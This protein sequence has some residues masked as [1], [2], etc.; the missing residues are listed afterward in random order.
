MKQYDLFGNEI[1]GGD[2]MK[3]YTTKNMSP[4]YEPK[5]KKPHPAELYDKTKTLRLINQINSTE[6][7]TEVRKFLLEAATRHTIFNYSK[8]ADFYAHSSKEVQVLMEHSALIIIDFKDSIIYEYTK[9][10][11]HI[12]QIM[13]NE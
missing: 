12:Q 5:G 13:I 7:P 11:E 2:D 9:L 3:K 10:D 1:A 6:M 8:I 4:V